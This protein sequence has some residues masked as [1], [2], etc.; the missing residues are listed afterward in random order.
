MGVGA[1]S[2]GWDLIADS[3]FVTVGESAASMAAVEDGRAPSAEYAVLRKSHFSK[4]VAM[5]DTRFDPGQRAASARFAAHAYRATWDY[6]NV[7]IGEEFP[8]IQYL[9]IHAALRRPKHI[10]MLVHNTASLRRR[11][12]LSTLG[13]GRL[14]DHWLCLSQKSKMDLE[15]RYGVPSKQITVVGSRVDTCF[16]SPDADAEVRMQ[17]CSAGAVNRDYATLIA[18]AEPL[19]VE[20]KIAAD[21]AWRYT[22]SNEAQQI[23]PEFVEMRSWGDYTNLRD[24]YASSAVVVVPLAKP[25]LSG[26]TVLLEAMAMARPIIVTRNAYIEDFVKDGDNCLLVPPGDSEAMRQK[27][28]YLLD[29]PDKASDLGIRAREWVLE[30]FTVE[31]YVSKIL[32]VWQ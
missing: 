16:F 14:V 25:S 10:A 6:P 8:G 7:Y 29:H 12:P 19:G 2:E 22:A 31:H 3:A 21:T 5:M 4:V 18:A 26:V 17:I 20:L 32:S 28:R 15:T 9:T 11:L 27:I 1:D 13:L 24:L 30:R 23:V